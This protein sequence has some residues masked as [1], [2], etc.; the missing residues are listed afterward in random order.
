MKV[1]SIKKRLAAV[2]CIN[3]AS[4]SVALYKRIKGHESD[5]EI[6]KIVIMEEEK[7]G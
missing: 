7:K 2:Q 4:L 5:E 1:Q 3:K 6:Q